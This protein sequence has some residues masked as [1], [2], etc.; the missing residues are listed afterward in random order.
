MPTGI[1]SAGSRCGLA[2]LERRLGMDSSGSGTPSSKERIGAKRSAAGA[3]GSP[4]VC[5]ARTGSAA[6]SPITKGKDWSGIRIRA[7][8]GMRRRR[9]SVVGAGQVGY[10]GGL[11]R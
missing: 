5:A 3:S 10:I 1:R 11:H 4:S 6:G 2:E 8:R 9:R 7:R